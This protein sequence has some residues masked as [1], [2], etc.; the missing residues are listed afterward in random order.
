MIAAAESN[1]K[2][3]SLELGGK[4]AAIVCSD[5]DIVK[6]VS[7]PNTYNPTI[8]MCNA[9]IRAC[10]VYHTLQVHCIC[11]NRICD[12]IEFTTAFSNAVYVV[13]TTNHNI[14][15]IVQQLSTF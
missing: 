9:Y 6:A 3:V 10:V 2:S 13:C 15:H 8:Q 4:S 7:V 12:H 11:S 1:L 14:C 5:A